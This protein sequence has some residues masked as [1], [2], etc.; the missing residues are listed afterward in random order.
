MDPIVHLDDD[1]PSSPHAAQSSSA[2]APERPLRAALSELLGNGEAW[3]F[4]DLAARLRHQAAESEVYKELRALIRAGAVRRVRHGVYLT[5]GPY[6]WSAPIEAEA[7]VPVI[8]S[9]IYSQLHRLRTVD[10]LRTLL[11]LPREV[12]WRS[13]RALIQ[14]GAVCT[15]EPLGVFREMTF[16]RR[17]QVNATQPAAPTEE[18]SVDRAI[19]ES[20]QE[21]R[22]YSAHAVAAHTD[23]LVRTIKLSLRKLSTL[24]VVRCFVF[25][26]GMYFYLTGPAASEKPA[27]PAAL[28]PVDIYAELGAVNMAT[29][30]VIEQADEGIAATEIGRRLEDVF[31]GS[32]NTAARIITKLRRSGLVQLRD[33][34][35]AQATL[36][37][38]TDIG[39]DVMAIAR[40]APVTVDKPALPEIRYEVPEDEDQT[41]Y[42]RLARWILDTMTARN[43]TVRRRIPVNK[44][45]LARSLNITKPH[46]DRCFRLLAPAGISIE[47]W[48]IVIGDVEALRAVL[49][50]E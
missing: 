6:D 45:I 34:V 47:G 49:T 7:G 13:L 8:Q 20:V 21:G 2:P 50:A 16:I 37:E 39:S 11:G 40:G 10:E 25:D 3:R 36:W 28:K 33:S 4:K 12:V 5:I 27:G 17:D 44:R 23:I 48:D 24:G 18:E 42:K 14:S 30:D 1:Q 35:A 46:L 38:A 22:L 32:R 41:A 29:L 19:L 43:G 26:D 15:G 31:R 9:A